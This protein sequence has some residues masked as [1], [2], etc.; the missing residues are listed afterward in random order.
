MYIRRF[1]ECEVS[2]LPGETIMAY[3]NS[4]IK[5]KEDNPVHKMLKPEGGGDSF[6]AVTDNSVELIA[7]QHG[8]VIDEAGVH[9]KGQMKHY[10]MPT[11]NKHAGIFFENPVEEVFIPSTAATWIMHL[12]PD[13]PIGRF[14]PF[15][16][17]VA[18]IMGII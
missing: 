5:R 16:M 15:V 1:L 2:E 14:T 8:I 18:K 13:N 10:E 6:V 3:I 11:T 4:E 9:I 7:G 17:A 12:L